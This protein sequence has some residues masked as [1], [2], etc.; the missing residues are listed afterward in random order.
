MSTHDILMIT[1]RRPVAVAKSLPRLFD[2]LEAGSRVWLWHNGD[3]EETLELV[4][5][6]ARDDRVAK[7]HHSRDNV[8][9]RAPT[10]WLWENSRAEYVSKVDDDC[11]ESPGWIGTFCDALDANP[12]L[13]VVAAWRHYPD[14]TVPELV[15]RKRRE[16]NGGH[17]VMQNHWVQGSGYMVRRADVRL[18]GPLASNGSFSS[19]CIDLARKGKVNGWYLPF[20]FEDHMDDPR[21]Q[22]ALITSD[23]DLAAGLPL[24]ARNNGVSTL[25]EWN[26]RN[27]RAALM[28]QRASLDLRLYGGAPAFAKR[29]KRKAM[30]LVRGTSVSW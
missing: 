8:R 20:I 2:T 27:R 11:L 18:G 29:V 24:S 23:L 5:S 26:S 6:F 17:A 1:H 9:L 3:H 22:N 7:F 28:L 4:R 12:S 19:W 14:E 21:S 13:G 15:A 25:G 30:N 16:L 10:M